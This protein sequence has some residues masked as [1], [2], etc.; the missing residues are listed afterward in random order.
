MI[1][2]IDS[3]IRELNS[4]PSNWVFRGHSKQSYHLTPTLFRLLNQNSTNEFIHRIEDFSIHQF[5]S[6]Y[7]LYNTNTYK[8]QTKL[9]TLALMQ[10]YGVPTRLLDFTESPYVALYFATENIYLHQDEDL[11]IWAIDYRNIMKRSI[12]EIRRID[13]K[14][15]LSYEEVYKNP[16]KVFEETIDRFSYD[17]LWITE[18]STL[19]LRIDRQLGTFFNVLQP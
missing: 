4:F 2:N 9:E 11:S 14:F 16:D 1:T 6:K 15:S 13:R 19:N 8:T 18:P 17:I 12:E 5:T 3:L 7:H 10:H